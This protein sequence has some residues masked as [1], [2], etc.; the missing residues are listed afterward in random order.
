M[1]LRLDVWE[2]SKHL[3]F[4]I[5]ENGY[6]PNIDN[7]LLLNMAPL[8][9]LIPSWQREPE[10]AWEAL[11]RGDYDWSYQAMDH[12]PKRVNEKCKT[13]KSYAIAHGLE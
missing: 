2:F 6:L 13:N 12:W 7:G 10:K 11:E 3:D 5:E 4:I 1:L 8:W 9:E